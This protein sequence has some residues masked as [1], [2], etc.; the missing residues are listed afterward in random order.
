MTE[1][2]IL[3]RLLDRADETL[4]D[5]TALKTQNQQIVDH[6]AKLNGQTAR[7]SEWIAT[8][9]QTLK[10]HDEEIKALK[11]SSQMSNQTMLKLGALCAAVTLAISQVEGPVLGAILALLK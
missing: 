3:E 10:A 7:N 8:N 2:T 9:S 1:S 5:L 11:T 4:K 6:L